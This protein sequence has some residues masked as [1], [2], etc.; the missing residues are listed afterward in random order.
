MLLYVKALWY[1]LIGGKAVDVYNNDN[2]ENRIN[3]GIFSRILTQLT[4]EFREA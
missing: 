2:A 3:Q 1:F 4:I